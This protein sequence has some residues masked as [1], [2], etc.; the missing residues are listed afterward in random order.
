MENVYVV[1]SILNGYKNVEGVYKER[2]KAEA[3][4]N[5]RKADWHFERHDFRVV[6]YP[7]Y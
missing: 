5:R 2:E 3:F 6:T 4:A 1:I 7:L